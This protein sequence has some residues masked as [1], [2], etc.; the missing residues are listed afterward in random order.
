VRSPPELTRLGPRRS[1]LLLLGLLWLCMLGLVLFFRDV[2]LPFAGALLVAYVIAPLVSRLSALEVRGSRLPR[3]GA[4]VLL[5]AGFF[6]AVY[7][8][9]VAALPQLYREAARVTMELRALLNGLTA[10]QVASWVRNGERWLDTHGIPIDLGDGGAPP[11]TGH[12]VIPGVASLATG[13]QLAQP[14]ARITLDLANAIQEGLASV[15]GFFRTHFLDLVG[16]S[17]ALLAGI[18]GGLFIFFFTLMVAAFVLVDPDRIVASFRGIVPTGWREDYDGLLAR[19]DEK[20]AGVVRGQLLICLINGTLT[21]VGLLLLKVK[22]SLLLATVAT[23]LS[24]IPIFGTIV[25][26]VPIVLVGVSQSWQTGLLALGWILII[27]GLEAYLLN[28]KILGTQAKI[29][30]ALIALALLVGER[31]YGLAGALFAVPVLSILLAAFLHV[32]DRAHQLEG[33]ATAPATA[34]PETGSAP[35]SA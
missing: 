13:S 15:S 22:F 6:L 35:R 17:R 16:Y 11:Q 27:H 31:T 30:P 21:L 4:I 34:E 29:H 28:P 25:S 14:G 12:N 8:F 26:T 33:A 32:R 3:W 9:A 24:F 18:A 23:V 2:L 7:L 20:L 10:D 19:V 1:Y 5:Y